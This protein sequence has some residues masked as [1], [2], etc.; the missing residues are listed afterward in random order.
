MTNNIRFLEIIVFWPDLFYE[1]IWLK[2]FYEDVRIDE[3]N[4]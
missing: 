2:L 4:N 3:T 1:V